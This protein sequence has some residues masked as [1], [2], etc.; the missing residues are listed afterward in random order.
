MLPSLAAAAI[1]RLL[2]NVLEAGTCWKDLAEERNIIEIRTLR[3][4]ILG[5]A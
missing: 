4:R 2:A 3:V 5:D 1:D